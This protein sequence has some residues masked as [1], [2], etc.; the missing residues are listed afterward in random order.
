MTIPVSSLFVPKSPAQWLAQTLA[1]GQ[2]QGLTST[3]WQSGDPILTVLA[4]L[5]EELA[6]EDAYGVSLRAQ[7][8][9]LDFAATGTVTFTDD[10]VQP[11]TTLVLPV[12][13][14]PSIPAQNPTGAPGLLDTLA[15]SVYDVKRARASS[16]SGPIY[17]ANTSGASLGTFVP[18]TFHIQNF[19]SGA[20]YTNQAGF[21]LSASAVVGTSVSNATATTPVAVTTTSNHGLTTGAVVFV[22]SLGVASDGFYAV[23]VTGLTTFTISTIGAGFF[24]GVTPPG[25][26]IFTPQIV[27]FAADQIG[28]VGNAGVGDINQLITAAPKCFCGNLQTFSGAPW[29]SNASL[30]AVCRAKLATLTPNGPAGAYQF[31][32]LAAYLVLSGQ[33]VFPPSPPAILS[34]LAAYLTAA[35]QPALASPIPATLTL[36]GGPITRT[37]VGLN[38]ASGAVTVTVANAGGAVGGCFQKLITAVTATSPIQVTAA[39]H[40]LITGD[41]AQVNGV[42]GTVGANG[43]FQITRVDANNITLNGS[44]GVGAYTSGGLLN[45]GDIYAVGAVVQEFATPNAVSSNVVSAGNIAVVV[46]ATVYVPAAFTGDYTTKMTAAIT[47]YFTSF[48]IGGLNVDGQSNVLPIGAVEGILFGAGQS[49]GIPYTLSVSSVTLNGTPNDVVL[50]ATGVA[51]LG[52]LAG[53]SVVGV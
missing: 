36:D 15:S 9:F 25:P 28:P 39:A 21:T 4:V 5:S 1:D 51:V 2:T 30:A 14:D 26:G 11:P 50:G 49:N 52:T 35:G 44:T 8:G 41:W 13:P 42:Q 33:V 18:G 7:G 31:W 47:A 29:Q 32:A 40:G 12:T 34:A 17:I 10:L 48:P 20:T 45:G 19:R 43:Q 23:T 3:S 37:L 46:A 6:K 24:P 53:I 22:Q 38:P 16:A 27:T